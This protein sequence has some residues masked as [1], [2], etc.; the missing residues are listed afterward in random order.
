[1]LHQTPDTQLGFCVYIDMH[2]A[3]CQALRAELRLLIQW[4]D[5]AEIH[6][7]VAYLICWQL[8]IPG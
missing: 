1:M 6:Y 2:T 5:A 3:V 7:P 8:V 4:P